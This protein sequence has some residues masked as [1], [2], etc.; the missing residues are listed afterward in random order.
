MA[1]EGFAA[2]LCAAVL[3]ISLCLIC[4]W[5]PVAAADDDAVTTA[6][7]VQT[8]FQQGGEQMERD[9][10]EAAVRV[11]EAQLS[12]INGNRAYLN[13]LRDAYRGHVKQLR[14]AHREEEAHVYLKRLE[15]LDPTARKGLEAL[16]PRPSHPSVT[17]V[18]SVPRPGPLSVA[19]PSIPAATADVPAAPINRPLPYKARGIRDEERHSSLDDPF[20][21]GN[22]LRNPGLSVLERANQEWAKRRYAAAGQLYEQAAKADPDSVAGYRDQWAYCKLSLVVQQLNQSAPASPYADLEQEIRTALSLSPRLEPQAKELLARIEERRVGS[23]EVPVRHGDSP[24]NGWT[25]AEST[26]FRLLHTHDR[27]LAERLIRVAERTYMETNR[28]WF[29]D[30][31]EAWATR[32]DLYLHASAQDYSR[33]TGQPANW[34]AHSTIQSKGAHVI[35]RRIDLRNDDP[36]LLTSSLPHEATHVILAG[37]FGGADLPRWADEG[38][39]ILNEPQEKVE[40]Y[41]NSLARYQQE[42]LLFSVRDLVARNSYP[43]AQRLVAYH[44]QS[45]SLTQYLVSQGGALR[46]TQFLQES[47]RYGCD[48]GLKRLYGFDLASLEQRWQQAAMG[49]PSI[50]SASAR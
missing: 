27:A 45:L 14:Q 41:Q 25:V 26:H 42:G 24:L 10:Y 40:W 1:R 33:G 2:I 5:S 23:P 29:N 30:E 47:M 48:V 20:N 7:A 6:L 32:C 28:K 43:E 21:P 37:R 19:V 13:R 3:F 11:L 44:A 49:K 50:Q 15:I 22:R 8:A 38:M 35:Y 46:F 36:E 31:G 12:H 9:N 18:P 4:C 39:A 17:P 16:P 34:P